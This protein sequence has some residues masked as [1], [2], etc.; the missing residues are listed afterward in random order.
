MGNYDD[1]IGLPHH[2]S[3][4][5]PQMPRHKRAA[6]FAPFAALKGYDEKIAE[7]QRITEKKRE[8]DE[9]R[10]LKINSYLSYLKEHGNDH[11]QT[12]ITYFIKDAVKDGGSY[13]Q[14][15]GEFLRI[16]EYGRYVVLVCG[17]RIPIDDIYDISIEGT[18]L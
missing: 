13:V 4:D 5:H 8:P 11:L 3:S 12:S 15:K 2:V 7:A 1:I 17:K 6:Q 10:I 14:D 9:D 16:D 18:E